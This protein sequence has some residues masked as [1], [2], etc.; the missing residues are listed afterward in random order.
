MW[1]GGAGRGAEDVGRQKSVEGTG[2]AQERSKT[3]IRSIL[4]L[5]DSHRKQGTEGGPKESRHESQKL[6]K[7]GPYSSGNIQDWMCILI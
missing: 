5:A 3:K 6:I 2:L 1:R 4:S 7:G